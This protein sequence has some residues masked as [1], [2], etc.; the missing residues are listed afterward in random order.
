[1]RLRW[2]GLVVSAAVAGAVPSS[3]SVQSTQTAETHPSAIAA[4]PSAAAEA[5]L[6]Q[7]IG[8]IRENHINSAGA[9]WPVL[10]VTAR[11]RISGA[12]STAD[13]YPAIRGVPKR[14][15]SAIVS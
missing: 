15:I 3:G 4:R 8:L 14:F 7:A 11:A 13:T 12:T 9:D 1:M 2:I 5:Y 6:E 10:I